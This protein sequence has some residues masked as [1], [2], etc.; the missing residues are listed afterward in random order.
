VVVNLLVNALEA[1]PG[2]EQAVWVST[3]RVAGERRIGLEV[4]DE[5]VGI[6]REHLS[7]LCDAFF[8]TKQHSGGTGLGLAITASLVQAHGGE[9]SFTSEPGQG[10][11]ARATFPE[12]HA[13]A[14][15][16]H[17]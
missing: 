7:Q 15:P 1:L 14:L 9:L 4:C 8:T 3:F 6:P 5:G 17:S 2:R 10:T 11:R 16:S 13:D 12:G